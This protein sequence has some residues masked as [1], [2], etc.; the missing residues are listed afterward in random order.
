MVLNRPMNMIDFE[1]ME[2]VNDVIKQVSETKGPGVFV[3]LSSGPKV[4]SSGFDLK[5]WKKATHYPIL[6]ATMI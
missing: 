6:T 2:K 3:T 1:F 5:L 4:F